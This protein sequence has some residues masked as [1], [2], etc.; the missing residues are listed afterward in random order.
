VK[1]ACGFTL[2]EILVAMVILAVLSALGYGAYRQ[3][4][5]S[6][7]HTQEAQQRTREIAMGLHTMAQDFAELSQRPVRDVTGNGR[8]PAL[9]SGD[10]KVSLVELTRMGWSNTAGVQ[11]STLQRVAYSLDRKVLKRS[12]QVVLDATLSNKP[13]E[14]DLLSRVE[15]AHL[16]YMDAN[17]NWIEN[18]PVDSGPNGLWQRP[19]AVEITV[20]FEDAG[21]IKRLVEVPG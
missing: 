6:T 1:R 20:T 18:W 9:K 10:G 11:R 14:R 15:S 4:R 12:Y 5:I 17:H 3:A 2:V 21:D 13:I 8:N 19:I 16:R 7:E